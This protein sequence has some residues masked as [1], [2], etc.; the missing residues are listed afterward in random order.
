MPNTAHQCTRGGALTNKLKNL[1]EVLSKVLLA[2][3]SG[4]D[5]FVAQSRADVVERQVCGH[6]DHVADVEA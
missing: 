1:L 5:P 3:V 2:V 6:V 4:W